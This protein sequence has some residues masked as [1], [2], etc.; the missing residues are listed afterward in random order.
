M[1][2]HHVLFG[3]DV[4]VEYYDY[5]MDRRVR[6]GCVRPRGIEYLEGAVFVCCENNHSLLLY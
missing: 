3:D 1:G 5:R 6:F 2:A 4:G